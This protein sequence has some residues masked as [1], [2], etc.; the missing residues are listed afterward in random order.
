MFGGMLLEGWEHSTP[1]LPRGSSCDFVW[2][3]DLH[4][5]VWTEVHYGEA[6]STADFKTSIIWVLCL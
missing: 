5:L 1:K 4:N 3:L 6:P 2:R